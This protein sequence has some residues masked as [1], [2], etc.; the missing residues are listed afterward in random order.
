[1]PSSGL[2]SFF[3]SIF[4]TSFSLSSS[5]FRFYFHLQTPT[6]LHP[7]RQPT[8]CLKSWLVASARAG[9]PAHSRARCELCGSK[10]RRGVYQA[11]NSLPRG[12]GGGSGRGFRAAAV[13]AGSLFSSAAR[14]CV[15]FLARTARR[16]R[17]HPPDAALTLY[18]A[19]LA[20]RGLGAAARGA[21]RG[22]VVG[23][24]VGR[25]SVGHATGYLEAL[26][27]VVVRKGERRERNFALNERSGGKKERGG[28]EKTHSRRKRRGK[29]TFPSL[30]PF[31]SPASACPASASPTP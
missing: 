14:G 8:S 12:G 16:A 5:H 21:R 18:A 26:P 28:E 4:S 22:A 11:L 29:K 13:D 23:G 1:M 10:W 7:T 30:F 19:T 31:S 25:V 15:A 24:R 27:G 20:V 6:P 9:K 2:F 17:T 3:F